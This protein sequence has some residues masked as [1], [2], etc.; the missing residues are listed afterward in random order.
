MLAALAV[1]RQERAF[2]LHCLHVEHG[3]RPAEESQGDAEAVKELCKRLQ[4]PCRVVSITPGKI[5][6]VAR[7][8]GLGIEGAARLFR[9]RVWNREVRRVGA[10]RVLVAHTQEDLLETV[11]MRFLRGAGPAGL[12][13]MPRE[14]GIVVRPLLAL[15]RSE[16]LGYLKDRDIPFRI[17]STNEDIQYLRNRIRHK[18]IPCLH[19]LFPRW[20][21]TVLAL[22][23]TQGLTA[24][25]LYA[26]SGERVRWEW[27]EPGNVLHTDRESFFAQPEVIRQEAL[28][29]AADFLVDHAVKGEAGA[30]VPDPCPSSNSPVPRVRTIRREALRFFTSGAV[31]ALDLGL[32]RIESTGKNI[33]VSAPRAAGEAGFAL[34]IKAPGI[35]TLKEITI[36]V[37]APPAEEIG[38]RRGRA[39]CFCARLPLVL[40]QYAPDDRIKCNS[41]TGPAGKWPS[42]C[43]GVMVAEDVNG[44]VAVIFSDKKEGGIVLCSPENGGAEAN[45]QIEGA[46]FMVSSGIGGID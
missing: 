8:G 34:L 36:E 5:A 46:W 33:L 2:T 38:Q 3:I 7:S 45:K 17:D 13:A 32:I 24:D 18:L 16:V 11:L 42:R 19:D 28:F 43:T 23:E 6:A 10:K 1:L 22:A 31:S 14:R 4:V 9:R 12:A 26:E 15:T 37:T 20:K 27:D 40:R 25:F 41:I 39:G 21:K 30:F 35:Y 44:L 29:Q